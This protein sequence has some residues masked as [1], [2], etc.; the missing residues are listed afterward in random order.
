[1]CS[2]CAVLLLL[3]TASYLGQSEGFPSGAPP[4]A[5]SSLSPNPFAHGAPPQTSAVPYEVDLSAFDDGSGTLSYI[6]GQTVLSMCLCDR[7]ELQVRSIAR[8]FNEGG[9]AAH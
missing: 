3:I 2:T 9:S 5:C 7:L 4:G 6:P 8:P 1:M